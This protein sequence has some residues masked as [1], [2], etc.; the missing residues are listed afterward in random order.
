MPPRDERLAAEPV[1]PLRPARRRKPHDAGRMQRI[2]I[3][4]A[5]RLTALA[6][7]VITYFVIVN[8][9][10]ERDRANF[11]EF[12][13]GVLVFAFIGAPCLIVTFK[14]V[15]F[16]E[17]AAEH[18]RRGFGYVGMGVFFIVGSLG[19]TYVLMAY[20]AIAYIGIG[21]FAAGGISII[22]GLIAIATGQDLGD[23][24]EQFE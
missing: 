6:I 22:V 9:I 20:A 18:R 11:T 19:I 5:V 2:L 14:G 23:A 15:N 1:A 3:D 24:L 13:V 8:S 7:P 12:L 21:L 17:E 4:L 16:S 10:E